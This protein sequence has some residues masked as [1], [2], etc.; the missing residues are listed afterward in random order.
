MSHDG[1]DPAVV[2]LSGGVG[3]ARMA[4]GLA[5]GGGSLTVVVN[6]G[7]DEVIYGLHV[8]P[9]VDTV[10][11][12][13]AGIEGPHGW[14]RVDDTFGV[15]EQLGALGIDNRFRIGDRDLATNLLRTARLEAGVPLSSITSEIAKQL[16]VDA[17][18]L[19]A[20][21]D[22][23]PTRVRSGEEW[24]TFQEYFVLRGAADIV[25]ELDYVNAEMAS[26]APGVIEALDH[27]GLV[28]IAPSNPPLSVWPILAIPGIREAL[29]RAG[30]V[31]A[32]SPLFGGKAL[33][34]PADRVM[35]SLGLAPGNQGVADAYQGLI[36]DLVIDRADV[37]EPINTSAVVHSLD[38]HISDPAAA[39][40]FATAVLALP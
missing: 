18:V 5:A 2:L 40:R 11:Y 37:N 27:A 7:D 22:R 1:K 12:T 39:A 34:G 24:L 8:S 35:A 3:G 32:V 36:T 6:V 20:T 29:Q 15:M 17:T 4:R 23:V 28:V 9:D 16:S 33:K 19:P 14:G 21:D 13:L 31:V 38:T 25:D 30:R 10:L 26:P